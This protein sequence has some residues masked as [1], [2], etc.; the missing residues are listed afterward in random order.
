MTALSTA[1]VLVRSPDPLAARV[2]DEI[3]ML[4]TRHTAYFGLDGAGVV[5]WDLLDQPLSIEAVCAH[6]IQEYE[7]DLD[8][9]RRDVLAFAAELVDAGLV[10]VRR[11][12]V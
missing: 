8:T 6:L 5:I 10:E 7:V 3:V 2:D 9:C 11:A 4:D 1:T 12:P